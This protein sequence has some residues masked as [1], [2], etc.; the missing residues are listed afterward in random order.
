MVRVCYDYIMCVRGFVKFQRVIGFLQLNKR[1]YLMRKEGLIIYDKNLKKLG[2][3][4]NAHNVSVERRV[5]QLWSA[6]FTL[7]IDDAKNDLCQPFNFVEITDIDGEYIGLFRIIPARTRKL[8]E[9]NEVTYHCEHVL[10]M[11]LNDV[12]FGY[13]HRASYNNRDNIS[14]VLSH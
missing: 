12:L 1:G 6:S 9:I 11:L 7:H 10:A 3:L 5:N 2:T 14:Y 13:H 8:I 4:E